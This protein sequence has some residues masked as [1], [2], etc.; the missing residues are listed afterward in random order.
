MSKPI[1]YRGWTGR[2][3]LDD[4]ASGSH[5]KQPRQIPP[6]VAVRVRGDVFRRADAD[7]RTA[8]RAAFGA[9]VDQSVG[10]FDDIE[11]VLDHDN[12]IAGVAQLVQ[13]LEPEPETPGRRPTGFVAMSS[14]V[15]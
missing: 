9:H 8:A 11:V 12:R 15:M 14:S 5:S 4:A 10:G 7:H 2:T 6:G 1:R 3:V 13:H